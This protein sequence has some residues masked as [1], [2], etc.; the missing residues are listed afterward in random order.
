[1]KKEETFKERGEVFIYGFDALPPS[2]SEVALAPEAA[3]ASPYLLSRSRAFF[4]VLYKVYPDPDAARKLNVE[5]STTAKLTPI[6][7][8][9]S[10]RISFAA[11][12]L[13]WRP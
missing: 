1:V 13:R 4:W 10:S 3:K 5:G 8:T 11:S 12:L 9:T 2:L 7:I 6:L